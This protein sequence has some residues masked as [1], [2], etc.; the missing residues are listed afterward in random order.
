MSLTDGIKAQTVARRL[1]PV[2]EIYSKMN[3]FCCVVIL[4]TLGALT[5]GFST[6][7]PNGGVCLTLVPKH[8][9]N[10]PQNGES[11]YSIWIDKGSIKS[12]RD[13]TLSTPDSVTG[14]VIK[15]FL[16]CFLFFLN[17]FLCL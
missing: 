12:A 2:C 13:G 8:K 14:I 11:P 16:N 17:L 6:G 15:L 1:Q 5:E 10:A 4:A 3:T 9:E 7:A